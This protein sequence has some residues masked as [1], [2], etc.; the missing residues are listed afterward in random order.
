MKTLCV[1]LAAGVL[2]APVAWGQT[3]TDP[4]TGKTT[5]IQPPPAKA[6]QPPTKGIGPIKPLQPMPVAINPPFARLAQLG[7]DGKII[8]VDGN[9]DLL[10]MPRN[11]F[12]DQACRDRVRPIV[13]AWMADVD[14]LM[15]DNLD[16]LEKI[17][18]PDGS[19]GLI[20]KVNINDQASLHAI[21]Q[22]MTMLMA[23]GPLSN[24]LELKEGFTREQSQR[25]QEIVSDYLQQV[26]NE[27]MA[28]AGVVNVKGAELTEEQKLAQVNSVSRF[29][30]HI[31]CRDTID[32]YHR[33]LAD[34]APVLDKAAASLNL[35]A[36][37]M[38]K[39]KG[40]ISAAMSASS[41][42][43]KRKAVRAVLDQLT[44]DQRRAVL[45]KSLEINGPCDPVAAL[46]P[47]IPPPANAGQPFVP[48]PAKAQ[49]AAQDAPK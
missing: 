37:E 19:V 4:A 12:I 6:E 43:D 7:P 26:M 48:P 16:F 17:E 36:A 22:M 5:V 25:N 38:A 3:V 41:V 39:L 24:H 30:Y 15:I 14:Q 33:Q 9:L 44:F 11:T 49:P 35:P 47:P 40:G 8:R 45:S 34:T 32:S 27:I 21:A 13:K 10:A 31:S 1:A 23:A 2:F 20:D 42:Q 18:P 28:D 46:G 29:L